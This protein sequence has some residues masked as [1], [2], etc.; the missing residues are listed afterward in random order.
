MSAAA[1]PL[2]RSL[3]QLQLLLLVVVLPYL[4]NGQG[5]CGNGSV[6]LTRRDA[7]GPF[8]EVGSPIRN[9]LAPPELVQDPA[10][11]LVINGQV[12]GNDCRPLAN[13]VVEAW[14]A[15][16]RDE[17]GD[18]Y[19][20]TNHRGQL[21][22]DDCGK[23][24]FMQNFPALYPGRPIPHI[25]YKISDANRTMLLVTQLYFEGAIPAQYNPDSS[26]IAEVINE[27]DG[28]RSAEFHIYVSIP[29]TADIDSCQEPVSEG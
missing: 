16:D 26:Q 7:L 23:F 28:R 10:D 11:V 25:H 21:V 1:A 22:A 13:A 6:T 2:Q 19:S 9:L 4:I 14:Y 12:F 27:V 17:F 5:T 20:P 24:M 8:Y 18:F 29:G 3:L 15:G